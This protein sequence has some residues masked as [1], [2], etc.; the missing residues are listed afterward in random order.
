[1]HLAEDPEVGSL[2][3]PCV[4]LKGST[5][6]MIIIRLLWTDQTGEESSSTFYKRLDGL[7]VMKLMHS[8]GV[9]WPP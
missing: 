9:P 2:I 3:P 4:F 7:S 1:M 6:M 8:L 5:K